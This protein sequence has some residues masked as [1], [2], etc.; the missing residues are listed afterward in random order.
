MDTK[1]D[2]RILKT[3]K[4]LGETF[5][6]LLCEKPFEDITVQELCNRAMVR[7]A[8]FYKH[9]A[10]KYDFFAFSVRYLYNSF[11]ASTALKTSGRTKESYVALIED[12][13]EFL[14][15]NEKLVQSILKSNLFPIMID[16]ISEEVSQDLTNKFEEDLTNGLTLPACPEVLSHFYISAVLGTI[17]WWVRKKEK[18]TKDE[19][20][21]EIFRLM[22]YA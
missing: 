21:S 18:M 15:S 9:F 4:A 16:I 14:S 12:V 19:L 6:T 11:P 1:T 5:F 10:D 20:I 8:T 3:H 22:N 7:R 17:Q 2:L 13:I